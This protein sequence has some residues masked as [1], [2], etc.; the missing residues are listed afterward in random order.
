MVENA[1]IV[2]RL[3]KVLGVPPDELVR[4]GVAFSEQLELMSLT[5]FFK[6]QEYGFG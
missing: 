1:K 4:K 3:S 5:L 2:E 6:I